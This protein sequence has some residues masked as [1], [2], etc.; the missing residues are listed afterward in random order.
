MIEVDF[1][2]IPLRLRLKLDTAKL[3]ARIGREVAKA[4]KKRLRRGGGTRDGQDLKE[5]GRLIRSIRYNKRLE[6]VMPQGKRADVS[7]RAG[8]NFGLMKIHISGKYRR[9]GIQ[10]TEATDP[11]GTNDPTLVKVI[12]DALEKGL[13]KQL[14]SGNTQLINKLRRR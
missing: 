13:A 7:R 8:G 10:R 5:T 14:R 9:E 2:R 6:Q 11:M 3:S 1:K 12:N 4:V